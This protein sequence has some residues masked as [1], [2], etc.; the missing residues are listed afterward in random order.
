MWTK[1]LWP[2]CLFI[3]VAGI[4]SLAPGTGFLYDD[5]EVIQNH[6]GVT[7]SAGIIRIFGER[8]FPNLPYYRPITRTTLLLQKG[9][10]GED[11]APFRVFNAMLMGL[12]AVLAYSLVRLSAFG[13]TQT[14]AGFAAALFALHPVASSCVYPVSSGRET[15]MPAVWM[16]IAMHGWLRSG[17]LAK[18]V[19]FAAF[20]GAL[21]SKEQAI[22]LP[23]LFLLADTLRVT[24]DPP[25][26]CVKRWALRYLPL[27]A[28]VT[29]YI[30]VRHAL[31]GSAEYV[32]SG[33]AGVPV[34]VLY[35]MQTVFAP[36]IELRYEPELNVWLSP[37]RLAFAIAAA[38]GLIAYMG[39]KALFWIGWFLVALLP[40]ANLLRQEALF[41]ERYVFLAS[42]GIFA[43]VSQALP[44]KRQWYTAA[45]VILALAAGV[46]VNR[47]K[48]FQDDVVFS[49]QWLATNPH[50][51]NAEYNLGFAL[52]R[53]SD[54]EG[55]VEHYRN[56]LRLRP[57]YAFAH[58]NL[59]NALVALNRVPEALPHFQEAVRLDPDYF[60]AY[61]NMGVAL[62]RNGDA[63]HGIAA[64]ERAAV[65]RPE[66]AAAFINL[67]N[68]YAVHGST[69]QAMAAFGRGLAL[70]PDSAEAHSNYAVL[71]ANSGRT[72][73]AIAQL[74]EAVRLNPDFEDARRNLEILLA[75]GA[76][77]G[78]VK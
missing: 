2:I 56:A 31:F 61:F 14:A 38:V 37:A 74:R 3:V 10:W 34:A 49:R 27:L 13:F 60:D 54:Y 33:F 62:C 9:I 68:A 12:A 59:A 6:Q 52:G 75:S 45:V 71:L 15:L 46:S 11:P 69:Q 47:A 8:H 19:A 76:S 5:H 66:S 51:V 1:L 21:L 78:G 17:W 70:A 7:D 39:G 40:T 42:F 65:L 73:E 25:G 43:M 58:N 26:R 53:Q 72:A 18:L 77:H 48:Y 32:F 50:S 41:D 36:F 29:A 57:D 22:V 35:G 64:L 20:A 67:G 24:P 30:A 28:I 63:E 23:L 4:Y 16:L 44:R 55:A